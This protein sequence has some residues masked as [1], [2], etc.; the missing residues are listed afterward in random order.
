M[1]APAV[2]PD[3]PGGALLEAVARGVDLLRLEHQLRLL[4]VRL[5]PVDPEHEVQ[6]A[7][8]N[9]PNGIPIRIS[10][11]LRNVSSVRRNELNCRIIASTMTPRAMG[12]PATSF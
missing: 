4:D 6:K 12:N 5:A 2:G 11:M 9:N 1:D 8:A 10:G 7:V 3:S